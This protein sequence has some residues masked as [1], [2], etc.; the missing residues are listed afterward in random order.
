LAERLLDELGQRLADF[1][2]RTARLTILDVERFNALSDS[3]ALH[4][5]K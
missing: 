5:A 1:D 2:G 3:D 4:I